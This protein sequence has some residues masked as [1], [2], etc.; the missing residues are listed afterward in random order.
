M[1]YN[2]QIHDYFNFSNLKKIFHNYGYNFQYKII[3]KRNECIATY[4]YLDYLNITI[5]ITDNFDKIILF[6]DE[7]VSTLSTGEKTICQKVLNIC[8]KD[9]DIFDENFKLN[10]KSLNIV[11][12]EQD[13]EN[14]LKIM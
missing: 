11:E 14:Q 13:L 6:T 4:T 7:N 2:S 5:E 12:L 8:V 1:T 3:S 10:Y 9:Y